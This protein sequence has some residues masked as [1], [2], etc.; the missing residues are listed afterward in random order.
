MNING[1]NG[2]AAGGRRLSGRG[3]KAGQAE[4]AAGGKA[5]GRAKDRVRKLLGAMPSELTPQLA[6]ARAA[7]AK[8]RELV[9]GYKYSQLADHPIAVLLPY[10]AHSYGL[11]Q[12]YALGVPLLAPSLR[13]LALLHSTVGIVSHKT[14][15]NL[16]WRLSSD[17]SSGARLRPPHVIFQNPNI[18]ASSWFSAPAAPDAPCCAHDP[19]DACGPA[20][21]AAWLRFADW[22]QW[23]HISYFDTPAELHATA[24]ALIANASRRREI[25]ARMKD[26]F[27]G[28]SARRAAYARAA[29]SRGGA[30]ERA[31]ARRA[32]GPSA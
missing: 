27:R 10:S 26:F 3:E 21:A 19:D 23:P 15:G 18:V 5:A 30:L 12:A 25:S 17:P 6:K 20:A 16:P 24:R 28:E 1:A 8:R 22:Y 14:A 31:A 4:Q 32:R 2:T 13:L 11:V 7:R 9:C 29:L